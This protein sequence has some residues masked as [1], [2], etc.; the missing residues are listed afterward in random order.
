[1]AKWAWA[2]LN[3]I[4]YSVDMSPAVCTQLY[5]YHLVAPPWHG[6]HLNLAFKVAFTISAP[7]YGGMSDRFIREQILK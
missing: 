4:V 3:N 6:Y 5:N 1:M 7:V 2:E